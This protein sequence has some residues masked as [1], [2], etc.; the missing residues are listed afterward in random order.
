[1][2]KHLLLVILPLC[3]SAVLGIEFWNSVRSG[4]VRLGGMLG[5]TMAPIERATSPFLY[6]AIV[7]PT[8]IG[9]VLGVL[10]SATFLL[11]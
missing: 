9:I 5:I 7:G 2:G 8:G 4:E 11:A 10:I 3:C 6:W 1:M